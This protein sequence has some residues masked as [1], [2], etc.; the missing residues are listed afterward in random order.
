MKITLY[1]VQ[2]LLGSTEIRYHFPSESVEPVF[3][4]CPMEWGL[5]FAAFVC[6]NT[7]RALCWVIYTLPYILL[8]VYRISSDI[9]IHWIAHVSRFLTPVK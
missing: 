4:N 5:G 6:I 3:T 9:D 2:R 7:T 8:A 1:R